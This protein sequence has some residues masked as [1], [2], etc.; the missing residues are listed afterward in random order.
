MEY[1]L[2]NSDDYEFANSKEKKKKMVN[3]MHHRISLALSLFVPMY[4][5]FFT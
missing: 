2:S 3:I 4:L 1:T 5:P